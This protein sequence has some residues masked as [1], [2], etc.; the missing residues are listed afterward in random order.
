V[1]AD[2]LVSGAG[3]IGLGVTTLSGFKVTAPP[4]EAERTA[5]LSETAFLKGWGTVALARQPQVSLQLLAPAELAFSVTPLAPQRKVRQELL[6]KIGRKAFEWALYA[7]VATAGSPAF[8]HDVTLASHFR[9]DE[10]LITEDEAERLVSWTQ[11]DQRLSLFLRDSTTGIQ[12][13]RLQ[14]RDMVP[15]DGRLPIP[16]RWFADADLVEFS[17]R[18]THDPRCREPRTS[19]GRGV[20]SSDCSMRDRSPPAFFGRRRG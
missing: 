1:D 12:N 6:L 16:T 13:V 14:G 3:K 4:I 10:V 8:Q 9:A 7:E 15:S 2:G 20:T 18:V 17:M 11:S 5:P 19:R